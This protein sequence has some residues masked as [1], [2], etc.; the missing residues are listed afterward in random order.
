ML[1]SEAW[2]AQWQVRTPHSYSNFTFQTPKL[3]P[4]PRIGFRMHL[5][6]SGDR[7]RLSVRARL[8]A[9]VLFALVMTIP[10]FQD[11]VTLTSICSETHYWSKKRILI[12][13]ILGMNALVSPIS[14]FVLPRRSPLLDRIDRHPT[15]PPLH[16]VDTQKIPMPCA[17]L[18]MAVELSSNQHLLYIQISR[19][20]LA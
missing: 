2:M 17:N 15:I 13:D 7:Q 4:Q 1:S 6:A 3:T 19:T 5:G 14:R 20:S 10:I 12:C 11:D 16:A 9:I 8:Q 18:N